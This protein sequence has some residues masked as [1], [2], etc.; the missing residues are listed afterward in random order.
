VF[1]NLIHRHSSSLRH[2]YIADTFFAKASAPDHTL[3]TVLSHLQSLESLIIHSMD[4]PE[5]ILL[6]LPPSLFEVSLGSQD[7]E[8]IPFTAFQTFLRARGSNPTLQDIDVEIVVK[9]TNTA[10]TLDKRWSS[11]ARRNKE[12]GLR[13]IFL[14]SG[15]R[16]N[17]MP[18]W[19][20]M[21]YSGF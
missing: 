8:L 7:W 2:L 3:L 17:P 15:A 21:D 10:P 19:A 12:P 1:L 5:S 11:F 14:K 9:G 13:V 6:H 16:L 4:V 20:S 18:K